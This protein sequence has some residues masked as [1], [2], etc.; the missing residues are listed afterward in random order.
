MTDSIIKT[1]NASK[2][3]WKN[4]GVNFNLRHSFNSKQ[5]LTAD[6]D[7]LKYDINTYQ[8]FQNRLDEPGGYEEAYKGNLPSFIDIVSF[9]LDHTI[10]LPSAIKWQSGFKTSHIATDNTAAY[11]YKDG[12]EWKEDLGKTNH[13]L[14]TENIHALY[15]NSEKKIK[16]WTLQAGLRYELTSYKANQLGN[17]QQKDSAFSRN[18]NSFFPSASAT[19]DADSANQFMRRGTRPKNC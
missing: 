2:N 16:H 7:V 12:L 4:L 9:K 1:T 14:Y 10:Q 8:A 6:V 5:E 3:S 11:F 18:Y 17:S 13:F 15:S 19:I